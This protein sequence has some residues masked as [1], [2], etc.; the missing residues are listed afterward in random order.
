MTDDTNASPW[1]AHTAQI[2]QALNIIAT[3]APMMREALGPTVQEIAKLEGDYLA[4]LV[5]HLEIEHSFDR[6]QAMQLA[7]IAGKVGKALAEA[8]KAAAGR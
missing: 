5:K 4:A 2:L 8:G 3:I 7:E 1:V 6:E